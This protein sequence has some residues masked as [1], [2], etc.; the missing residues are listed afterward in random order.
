MRTN[1]VFI[2]EVYRIRLMACGATLKRSLEFDPLH[3]PGQT[4]PKRRRCTPMA[5]S[6]S[7]PQTKQQQPSPFGEVNPK[8]TTEQYEAFLK[9]NHDQ[10][11]KRFDRSPTTCHDEKRTK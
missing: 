6:P 3:S 4:T 1:F 5:L 7:T 10:I 2:Q 8:L 9:F 11:H